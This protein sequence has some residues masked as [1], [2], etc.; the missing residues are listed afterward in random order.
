MLKKMLMM[1]VKKMRTEKY[2]MSANSPAMRDTS[3]N[4]KGTANSL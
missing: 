1:D 2:M 4:A 3:M